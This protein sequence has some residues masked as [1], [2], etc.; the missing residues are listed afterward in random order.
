METIVYSTCYDFHV[1]T[2]TCTLGDTIV[3]GM[4]NAYERE[5][6]CNNLSNEF[7]FSTSSV[8]NFIVQPYIMS[9][10]ACSKLLKEV[11]T[12][13]YFVGGGIACIQCGIWTTIAMYRKWV[14]AHVCVFH[15]VLVIIM[16][17]CSQI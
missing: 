11:C 16:S 5:G 15:N 17:I 1:T 6:A 10:I 7:L 13:N 8:T 12:Y 3:I 9:F 4:H 14:V 2:H